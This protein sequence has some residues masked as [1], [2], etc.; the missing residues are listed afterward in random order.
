MPQADDQL[1]LEAY[2]GS[3]E[4]GNK[5]SLFSAIDLC[6]RNGWPLPTWAADAFSHGVKRIRRYETAS[7]DEVFGKPRSKG[8]HID[9][10]RLW[11]KAPNVYLRI[12]ALSDSGQPINAELFERVGKEF[13][14]SRTVCQRMW[15]QLKERHGASKRKRSSK[16]AKTK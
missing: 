11:L 2:E 5:F 1:M 14:V 4:A 7:L 3:Y 9:D 6:A 15:V 8:T 13:G 12:R 16:A 10:A